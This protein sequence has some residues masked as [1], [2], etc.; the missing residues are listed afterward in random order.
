[1]AA[2]SLSQGGV[3]SQSPHPSLSDLV[4]C[5]FRPCSAL[6]A[7]LW[8]CV[9]PPSIVYPWFSPG[10]LSVM[11]GVSFCR[12]WVSL[13]F[14]VFKLISASLWQNFLKSPVL[15]TR[16]NYCSVKTSW[17]FHYGSQMREPVVLVPW[18]CLL[19]GYSPRGN[20]GGFSDRAG[21]WPLIPIQGTPSTCL[22]E[23]CTV[24][25]GHEPWGKPKFIEWAQE[26]EPPK[27]TKNQKQNNNQNWE[28]ASHYGREESEWACV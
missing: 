4:A 8:Q 22:W 21:T 10:P 16:W 5:F 13:F 26:K 25:G 14:H 6:F 1:M 28:Q 17:L 20:Q 11:P 24:E 9:T 7:F 15:L 3:V 23:K 18:E 12:I 27:H 19:R 2:T